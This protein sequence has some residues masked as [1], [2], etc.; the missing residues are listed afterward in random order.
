MS[1]AILR[2]TVYSAYSALTLRRNSL[3]RRCEFSLAHSLPQQR[4]AH[5]G[6]ITFPPAPFRMV[7]RKRTG[8]PTHSGADTAGFKL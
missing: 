7:G 6:K 8:I 3:T 1:T 4:L 2:V 5:A